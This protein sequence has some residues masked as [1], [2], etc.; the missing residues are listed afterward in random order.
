MTNLSTGD[1]TQSIPETNLNQGLSGLGST[2]ISANKFEWFIIFVTAFAVIG[3]SEVILRIFEVPAYV[4]PTPSQIAHSFVFNFHEVAPHLRDTLLQLAIGY[5]IGASIGLI[6]AGFITQFPF[7]EKI[8]TPYILLL[9]TTPTL[10]LVPLLILNFGFGY[11]PRVIAIA[12]AAGPI[13]MINA[14]TG[15]R[16]TDSNKIALATVYGASTLQI[17]MKIRV[18][19]AMPMIIVGL[20]MG[21]IF[22]VITCI[23]AEMAGGGFGLGSRLT[24]YSSTLRTDDFFAVI[25]I[26]AILGILIYTFFTWLGNKLVSWQ[27]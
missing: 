2:S 5:T 14:T 25:L 12:L 19:M 6:L 23:G 9:V 24:T 1:N 3:G 22:S 18:A 26:L 15:F 20:M 8:I 27:S 21:A 16:R 13:V 10:A 11:T 17:F 7:G 4:F